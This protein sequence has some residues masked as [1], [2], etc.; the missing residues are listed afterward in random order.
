MDMKRFTEIEGRE[1]ANRLI[2]GLDVYSSSGNRYYIEDKKVWMENGNMAGVVLLSISDTLKETWYVKKPF[3]VRAEMLARPNEWVGA[4][5][6]D[7]EDWIRVGFDSNV[8]S[9]VIT[10][11]FKQKVGPDARYCTVANSSVLEKC[12]PIE[13]VP[14]EEL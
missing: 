11:Y 6:N 12:I 5:K 10:L 3:D 14:K 1:A 7:T 4:F 8:M 9:V 13:D 2:D